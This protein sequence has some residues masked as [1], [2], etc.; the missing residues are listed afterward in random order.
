MNAPLPD[1][2]VPG[3]GDVALP[4]RRAA[5]AKALIVDAAL[6]GE[7]TTREA[8]DLISEFQLRHA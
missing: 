4:E 5:R 6:A 8:E 3:E 7:I 2:P 1:P